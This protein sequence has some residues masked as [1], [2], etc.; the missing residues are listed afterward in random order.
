MHSPSFSFIEPHCDF[1]L[2]CNYPC[3][4]PVGKV[5]QRGNSQTGICYSPRHH[6]WIFSWAC[7]TAGKLEGRR[8]ASEVA[9][10]E[11]PRRLLKLNNS[12]LTELS[13]P[14]KSPPSCVGLLKTWHCSIRTEGRSWDRQTQSNIEQS[15]LMRGYFISVLLVHVLFKSSSSLSFTFAFILFQIWFRFFSYRFYLHVLEAHVPPLELLYV[16]VRK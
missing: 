14:W 7:V 4:L 13:W 1:L 9:Q 15:L 11:Q 12:W 3:D 6:C 8:T 2:V 16:A 10:T 5:K